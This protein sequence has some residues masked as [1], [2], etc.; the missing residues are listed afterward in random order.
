[1]ARITRCEPS[2]GGPEEMGS[3]RSYLSK[4]RPIS[5]SRIKLKYLA[6][7]QQQQPQP[8]DQ[9]YPSYH[10]QSSQ[11]NESSLYGAPVVNTAS[12]SPRLCTAK[13]M[14]WHVNSNTSQ[15]AANEMLAQ[16][17]R[18]QSSIRGSSISKAKSTDFLSSTL[19]Q[20]APSPPRRTTHEDEMKGA[21]ASSMVMISNQRKLSGSTL[22]VFGGETPTTA[23]SSSSYDDGD[24]GILVYDSGQS[25]MLSDGH[26]VVL[27]PPGRGYQ[28][29]DEPEE[30]LKTVYLRRTSD[31]VGKNFGLL[32]SQIARTFETDH[33][34]FRIRHVLKNRE[35]D[36]SGEL[37]VGDEIVSVNDVPAIELSFDQMQEVINS[38]SVLRLVVQRSRRRIMGHG[39]SFKDSARDIRWIQKKP[40]L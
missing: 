33:N 15:L 16:N 21:L 26:S 22:T 10:R 8:Q 29:N 9:I 24:S 1:M 32:I 19:H 38:K 3:K 25:S 12:N 31:R 11:P 30:Q 37:Q 40:S 18:Q 27:Q 17:N 6:K 36:V 28:E 39:G 13:S 23:T 14:E 7:Q 20:P 5:P 35:A 34:R 2:V 4:R